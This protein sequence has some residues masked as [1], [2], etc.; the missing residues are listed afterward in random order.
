MTIIYEYFSLILESH[1]YYIK[2]LFKENMN[3]SFWGLFKVM[4]IGKVLIN[5]ET[6]CDWLI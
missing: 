6:P 3:T 5:I 4:C 2:C 1:S